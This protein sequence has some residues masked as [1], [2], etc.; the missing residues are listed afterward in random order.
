MPLD[1]VLVASGLVHADSVLEG[2][3]GAI[4]DHVG[5]DSTLGDQGDDKEG[6]EDMEG[7]LAAHVRGRNRA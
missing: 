3:D 6:M 5:D 1:M 4:D 2:E 7:A